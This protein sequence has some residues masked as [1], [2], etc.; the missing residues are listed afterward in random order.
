[1]IDPSFLFFSYLLVAVIFWLSGY[2]W[3]NDKEAK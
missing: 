3:K 1:M 2:Y